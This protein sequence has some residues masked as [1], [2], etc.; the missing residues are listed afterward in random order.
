MFKFE[1]GQEVKDKIT[2]FVGIIVS[3]AEHLTGCNRYGVQS[4]KL[5]SP[6]ETAEW[7]WF[8]EHQLIFKGKGLTLELE[9]KQ[10]PGGPSKNDEKRKK[11]R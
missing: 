1:L 10:K 2:G 5:K 6:T 11:D 3:R 8:D 9:Q 4:R 7:V